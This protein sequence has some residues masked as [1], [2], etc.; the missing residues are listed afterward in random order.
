MRRWACAV[1]GERQT[2]L[3]AVALARV[4]GV[5]GAKVSIKAVGGGGE[6]RSEP[7][8]RLC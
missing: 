7:R 2:P 6:C 1:D 5:V 8:G 4:I 3:A